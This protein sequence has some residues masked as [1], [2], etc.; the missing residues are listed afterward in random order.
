MWLLTAIG[1]TG[2]V[3]AGIFIALTSA[4]FDNGASLALAGMANGIRLRFTRH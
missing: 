1:I 2:V 4:G 3:F